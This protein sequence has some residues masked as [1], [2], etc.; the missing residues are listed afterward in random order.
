VVEFVRSRGIKETDQPMAAGDLL[1]RAAH[2]IGRGGPGAGTLMSA[3]GRAALTADGIFKGRLLKQLTGEAERRE[4]SA[5]GQEGLVRLDAGGTIEA[6]SAPRS[7]GNG[8]EV[9]GLLRLQAPDPSAI[10]RSSSGGTRRA[11]WRNSS[12]ARPRT[13]ID[14]RMPSRRPRT[15]GQARPGTSGR[16][17]CAERLWI[18]PAGTR[19]MRPCC[20]GLRRSSRSSKG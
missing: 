18:W 17:C 8:D 1:V 9:A 6:L 10:R 20:C 16:R 3:L 14:C 12:P 4:S 15:P 19:A 7:V 2:A 13:S 5:A 11:P